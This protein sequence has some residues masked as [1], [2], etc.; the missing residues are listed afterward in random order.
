MNKKNI[1]SKKRSDGKTGKSHWIWLLVFFSFCVTILVVWILSSSTP[2]YAAAPE[3]NKILGVQAKMPFQILI[4]AYLPRD[5][6]RSKVDIDVTQNG[7]SG[8]P[9][10]QLAYRTR[11]GATLFI[12]Q[13][14]PGHPEKEILYGSLPIQTKWGKGWMLSQ[15]NDLAALWVD[16]G[17]LR[18]SVYIQ[19]Q[20][21]LSKERILQVADTLGPASNQQVFSFS[22]ATQQIQAAEPPA[23]FEVPINEQGIQ[24]ITLVVTP[25]G[26]SPLRFMV[27]KGIPVKL[28]FRQLG[29]VGCGNEL[30]FPTSPSEM[31][32]LRL[33][34]E[35]DLQELN[36]T[37]T[38]AGEY[39]F[40]CSHQMYRGVMIVK[41]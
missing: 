3:A 8:E 7:P 27:R 25:G 9:M 16:V 14:V 4:P 5:F 1:T 15:G 41:N 19:D 33:E 40:Y 34:N 24:E 6:D 21:V 28:I 39:Q 22:V 35:K 2:A 20:S 30:I 26:Y 13:W 36:F 11:S 10:V 17:P 12:R 31:S 32:E 23:A 38:Q 29:Q 18:V 37:P